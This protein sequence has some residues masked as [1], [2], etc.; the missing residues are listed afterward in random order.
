MQS[1]HVAVVG[2]A[3]P[4]VQ[5]SRVRLPTHGFPQ[6]CSTSSVPDVT[7]SGPATE[8]MRAAPGSQA[9]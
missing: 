3:L 1:R 7:R 2:Q 4:A 8:Q 5:I 9:L 6:A